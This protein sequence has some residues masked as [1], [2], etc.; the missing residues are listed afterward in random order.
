[1]HILVTIFDSL[2]NT[3]V[4]AELD[5]MVYL[6]EWIGSNIY[7]DNVLVPSWIT[8]SSIASILTGL[9]P[10]RHNV[11]GPGTKLYDNIPT[12]FSVGR[13]LGY[14]TGAIFERDISLPIDMPEDKIDMVVYGADVY[15]P[16]SHLYD[17]PLMIEKYNNFIETHENTIVV[18][19]F[20]YT[21]YPY[22]SEVD[23]H[24]KL[25]ID[26][27]YKDLLNW[28]DE[29]VISGI[30]DMCDV[31]FIANDHGDDL[32]NTR[33][34]HY[35]H[36]IADGV[37]MYTTS[38][39]YNYSITTPV[40]IYSTVMNIIG[41]D[42]YISD[43][44]DIYNHHGDRFRYMLGP[45]YNVIDWYP[46]RVVLHL[47]ADPYI[48]MYDMR[49]ST[50]IDIDDYVMKEMMKWMYS[51][52]LSIPYKD[53]YKD[54]FMMSS[55]YNLLWDTKLHSYILNSRNTLYE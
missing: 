32:V 44:I 23:D 30:T 45:L 13:E 11:K 35:S 29:N 38:S 5:N 52:I 16:S 15:T 21:H 4:R 7:S 19:Y 26:A 33:G 20:I 31:I 49:D 17:V 36:D 27:I 12:I 51:S 8:Y 50:I 24:V 43:G 9:Y 47:D 55:T 1:M 28:T 34:M 2:I 10:I 40:D 6:K 18:M 54:I 25:G 14:S 37:L 22:A 41:V 53:V 42:S 48:S 39:K 3:K 46:F